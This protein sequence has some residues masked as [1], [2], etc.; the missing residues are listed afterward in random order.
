MVFQKQPLY[1]HEIGAYYLPETEFVH[2][3]R[4][5]PEYSK[6]QIVG[7]INLVSTM[8]GWKRKSRLEILEKI[9]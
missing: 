1:L 7:L 6:S 8:K 5:H 9:E 4:A 3:S 2:W